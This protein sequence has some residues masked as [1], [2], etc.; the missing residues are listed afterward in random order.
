LYAGFLH[1]E[2]AA[3]WATPEPDPKWKGDL[4]LA[5]ILVLYAYGGWNDAVFVAAEVRKRRNIALSLI[6]GTVGITLIYVAINAA[7]INGLG[8]TGV[9]E[10]KAVAADVLRRL[11]GEYGEKAEKI[12]CLL[13][14]ISALGAINGLVFTG[15]RVYSKLGS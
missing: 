12:M 5:M 13:V 9:R 6:L 8:F 11:P 15:S 4:G 3:A 10:S 2:T 14:M 7:Y 1:G